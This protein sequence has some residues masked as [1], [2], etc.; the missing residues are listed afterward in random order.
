MKQLL[1]VALVAALL[2]GCAAA[3]H[4]APSAVY[5]ATATVRSRDGMV[6][7]EVIWY[8]QTDGAFRIARTLHP[9]GGRATAPARTVYDGS[10]VRSVYRVGSGRREAADVVGSRQFVTTDAGGLALPRVVGYIDDH[11]RP[12]AATIHGEGGDGQTVSMSL[13]QVPGVPDGTFALPHGVKVASVEAQIAPGKDPKL[14]FPVYWLGASFGGG[15]A[16]GATSYRGER[17]A[18]YQ[19]AYP[20]L[21]LSETPPER[22]PPA[23]RRISVGGQALGV[24][25]ATAN[26]RGRLEF[27][28]SSSHGSKGGI[29]L[30][31]LSQSATGAGRPGDQALLLSGSRTQ[32]LVVGRGVKGHADAIL[33]ALRPAER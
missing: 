6:T 13:K 3:T 29:M 9:G 16:T 10:R 28:W 26:A 4:A 25:V 11:P 19:V 32:I 14:A 27:D 22:A 8:R 33:A 18:Y 20:G 5:R 17:D 12:G 2:C 30:M 23:S 24:R 31:V 7:R 21:M 15:S 1:P